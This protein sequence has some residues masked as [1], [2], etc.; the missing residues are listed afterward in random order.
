MKLDINNIDS[1][2][3]IPKFTCAFCKKWE[4]IANKKDLIENLTHE[5]II[6]EET[7]GEIYKEYNFIQLIKCSS[8]WKDW[9]IK[10]IRY[11]VK[12][13][14]PNFITDDWFY[15]EEW[16]R[17]F[18]EMKQFWID[19]IDEYFIK[20]E[21]IF[22]APLLIDIPESLY[23]WNTWLE[24]QIITMIKKSFELFWIDEKSCANKI[25]VCIEL[26]M[27]Y[28]KIEKIGKL[29]HRIEKYQKI[30]KTYWDRLLA[31]KWIWNDGSHNWFKVDKKDL[32]DWYKILED[33]LNHIFSKDKQKE[34]DLITIK[35]INSHKKKR[36]K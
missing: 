1:F 7:L 25:R 36:E 9:V 22:P 26:I 14:N 12:N 24:Y 18:E 5:S 33:V 11:P 27:D 29:H 20:I 32:I 28:L 3:I 34:L 8:C 35:I 16:E 4:L 30:N 10:W 15:D 6:I 21:Y 23:N 17:Y 2:K 31:L 13:Y 19:Y